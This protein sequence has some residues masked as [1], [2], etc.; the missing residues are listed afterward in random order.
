MFFG[1]DKKKVEI[2]AISQDRPNVAVQLC[3]WYIKRAIRNKLTDSG[4]KKAHWNCHSKDATVLVP[5]LE[6]CWGSL[7]IRQT[8]DNH[9]YVR[10]KCASLANKSSL[11]GRL[12][13]FSFIELHIFLK[14]SSRRYNLY[15]LIHDRNGIQWSVSQIHYDCII[16]LYAWCH[17]RNNYRLWLYLYIN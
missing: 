15:T 7:V 1:C 9:R 4:K 12:D 16:E 17:T 13:T 5:T 8:D 10:R 2:I 6:I 14:M 11:R 3:Y